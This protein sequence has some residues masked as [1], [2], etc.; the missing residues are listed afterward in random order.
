MS[1]NTMSGKKKT[2]HVIQDVKPEDDAEHM[3]RAEMVSEIMAMLTEA[4]LA[5]LRR[6]MVEVVKSSQ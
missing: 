6:I 4:D 1:D 3:R 2:V 5:T